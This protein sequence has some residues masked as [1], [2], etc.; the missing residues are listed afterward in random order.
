MPVRSRGRLAVHLYQRC[1]F[2]RVKRRL[3]RDLRIPEG[4]HEAIAEPLHNLSPT[5]KNRRLDRVGDLAQQP[6]RLL[7]SRL[8][9]PVR[10]ADQ[11]GEQHRNID[12]SAP[13]AP[14]LRNPLPALQH[15]QSELSHQ[16]PRLAPECGKLANREI[17]GVRK[18]LEN[19]S[20]I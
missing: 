14:R 20:A 19:R 18:A 7:V 5:L 10:K 8:Q 1:T 13:A 2:A 15:S 17:R 12:D 11:V 6:D 9:S 4:G 16:A 3:G